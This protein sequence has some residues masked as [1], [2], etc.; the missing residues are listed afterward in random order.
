MPSNLKPPKMGPEPTILSRKEVDALYETFEAVIVALE[1]LK[2]DYIVTGGSLLGAIRQH[3]ILFRDDDIDIAIIGKGA[4]SRVSQ[5]LQGLLGE[6]FQY[7]IAPW[8]GGDR[9]RPKKMPSVFLDL[10]CLCWYETMEQ[11]IDVIGVKKNGQRQS[12]DYI[13]GIT[14]SIRKCSISQSETTSLFPFWHFSTRKAVEMWTKEVYREHELFPLSRNPKFGPLEGI[15]GPRMP[16]L[17]LKRAFGLD[18]FDVYYQSGSLM[19]AK[20]ANKQQ[21]EIGDS[22]GDLLKPLV[23]NGGTW[24]GSEKAPLEEEVSLARCALNHTILIL[25]IALVSS[26]ITLVS[27]TTLVSSTITLV[28]TTTVNAPTHDTPLHF[29]LFFPALFAYAAS[30]PCQAATDSPRE[31]TVVY[32]SSRAIHTRRGVATRDSRVESG[33]S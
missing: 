15:K 21:G 33:T 20:E 4:Y 31:R 3:S 19:V 27:T 6:D 12:D 18:C 29:A 24:Q 14:S 17:L 13:D 16:V 1:Q 11:L 10:F 32:I 25:S 2:V 26:T 7:V 23:L 28:S 9:V 5:N 22:N 8:E 30:R